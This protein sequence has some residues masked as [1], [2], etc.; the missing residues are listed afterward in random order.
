MA[1]VA[2]AVFATVA[3]AAFLAVVVGAAGGIV[4]WKMRWG[5]LAGVPAVI[6]VYVLLAIVLLG[7]FW[8]RL[9]LFFGMLPL[10]QALLLAW[11]IARQLEALTRLHP[12]WTA[13]VAL[14]CSLAT[15]MLCLVTG[16]LNL[17]APVWLALGIVACLILL[18]I[19]YRNPASR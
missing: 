7:G 5:L 12:F 1:P 10:L 8:L 19:W 15:G 13:L 2:A 14:G 16:R 4:V 18:S 9:S 11:F 6:G 3:A 17:Y